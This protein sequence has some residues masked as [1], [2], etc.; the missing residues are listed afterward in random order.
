MHTYASGIAKLGFGDRVAGGGGHLNT[1]IE[2]G[3]GSARSESAGPP[4]G[5]CT[6]PVA[7]PAAGGLASWI[8]CVHWVAAPAASRPGSSGFPTRATPVPPWSSDWGPRPRPLSELARNGCRDRCTRRRMPSI[9]R[10]MIFYTKVAMERATVQEV[11]LR[12]QRPFTCSGRGADRLDQAANV[13]VAEC[14]GLQ[15]SGI[16]LGQRNVIGHKHVGITNLL[17]NLDCFDEVDFAFVRE[18]L[19]KVVAV[20]ANV[21]KV[22]VEDFLACAKISNHIKYLHRWVLEIF[23][24]GSLAKVKPVVSTLLDGNE[25]LE[26]VHSAQH[27]VYA[28]ISFRRHT[29]I[30]RMAG[31]SNLALIGHR[32]YT[33][34]KIRNT[35]P[36]SVSVHPPGP[37]ERCCRMSLGEIPCVVHRIATT[38]YPPGAKN[39]ENAHVVLNGRKASQ[40]TILDQ[41]LQLFDVPITLRT[42]SQHDGWMLFLVDETGLQE[43]RRNA[44]DAD[45]IFSGHIHHALEFVHGCVKTVTF[46]LR[47]SADVSHA[48][49]GEVL[50]VR[51]IG[52]RGLAS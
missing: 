50:E 28:L 12:A 41:R 5:W 43:W 20:A 17:V 35:L 3:Q 51:V 1:A 34:K 46:D 47:I 6:P 8:S 26:P 31:H 32:N 13:S 7:T 18:D 10:S 49:A 27:S 42:L 15:R 30:L 2:L 21:A 48:I 24:D 45:A 25:F 23:G 29:R 37:R 44:V 36:E 40:R 14:E 22:H 11:I 4:P 38:R 39:T 19:D 33:V 9:R 52:W 16:G